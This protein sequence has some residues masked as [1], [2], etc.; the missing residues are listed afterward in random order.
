MYKKI[1][2]LTLTMILFAS[3]ML[4]AYGEDGSFTDTKASDWF[5]DALKAVTTDKII[6]GYPDGSFKPGNTLNTDQ[7]VK[8]LCAVNGFEISNAE[9][10]WAQ[11]YIDRAEELGWF[12]NVSA[13]TYN[14]PISRYNAMQL[15]ANALTTLDEVENKS[16]YKIFISDFNDMPLMYRDSV[17]TTF[18]NGIIGGY[19]DQSFGGTNNLTRAEAAIIIHRIIDKGVRLTLKDA[20]IALATS[21]IFKDANLETYTDFEDSLVFENGL[22]KF[23]DDASG[24]WLTFDSTGL[25]EFG[26]GIAE[27]TLHNV[28][29]YLSQQEGYV[30]VSGYSNNEFLISIYDSTD[31]L[32]LQV[33]IPDNE[34]I[35]NLRIGNIY[36]ETLTAIDTADNA[37]LEEL[38]STMLVDAQ[39]VAAT[40]SVDYRTMTN[41]SSPKSIESNE[42]TI[43]MER[44]YEWFD[45]T[46]K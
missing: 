35:I 7:L 18:T 3:S 15:I 26:V 16:Y 17:L 12:D 11:N 32:K 36:D 45:I 25:S 23:L 5:A 4:I 21:N 37:L 20:S 28:L 10:Y 19:P 24:Q 8:M 33:I 31:A 29:G 22:F 43:T 41:T 38:L 39:A 14:T 13:T 1:L 27:N 44:N 40:I 30:L 6:D 42:L 9:G 34:D 2:A 46:I